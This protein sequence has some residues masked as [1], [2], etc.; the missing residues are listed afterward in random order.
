MLGDHVGSGQACIVR[1]IYRICLEDINKLFD[2]K[3]LH[4][5]LVEALTTGYLNAVSWIDYVPKL[6]LCM[7][8]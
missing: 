7:F 4:R 6:L 8:L 2:A 5:Y 3:V 1:H